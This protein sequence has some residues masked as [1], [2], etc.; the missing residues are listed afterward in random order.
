MLTRTLLS[1]GLTLTVSQAIAH[2]ASVAIYDHDRTETIRG[3][4]DRLELLNPH[5]FIHIDVQLESGERER[6]VIEGPGKL[7]LSR[8]GWTDDTL[9]AGDMVEATGHPSREGKQTMWLERLVLPDGTEYLDPALE[10]QLAIEAERRERA[11][12]LSP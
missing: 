10:D 2:H 3:I 12:Q 4:V 8:R 11:R 5:A 9:T 1:V 7:S 6:W